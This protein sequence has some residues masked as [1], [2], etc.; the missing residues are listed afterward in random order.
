M[1]ILATIIAHPLRKIAGATNAGR[2]LSVAT[3]ELADVELAIMWDRDETLTIGKLPVRH[4]RCTN[5]L[6]FVAPWAPRSVRV[7][8]YDSKIPERIRVGD[9]DLVHIH[10]LVPTFA[11]ERVARACRRRGIPYVISTHGFNELSRYAAING[12]GRL[13]S[14]LVD[15]AITRPFRR[16]VAGAAGIFALSDREDDMLASL[17]VGEERIHVVT[18]GVNEFYLESPAAEELAAARASFRIGAGPI[19]LFMGSLHR[20]KGVDVFL[21][22]LRAARGPF[23]AVVA[24]KFK[25]DDERSSLLSAARLDDELASRVVFTG[26]VSDEELR[27]LYHIADLFV[28]PTLA[29]SLPLV[30]LEAMACGLPVVSTTVGGIPFAVRPEAGILVPPG[31]VAAVSLAV[32]ELL[33]D[34]SRRQAMG[35]AARA[36]VVETFRWSAAAGRALDG[37]HTVLEASRGPTRMPRASTRRNEEPV[38]TR[39]NKCSSFMNN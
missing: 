30:V 2:D 10:N 20:Y 8:L 11:A 15:F 9:H 1:K 24:G 36:R 27:A 5:P 19:L 38:S 22:S 25:D 39:K 34:P 33:A 32:N 6:D 14:A 26:G 28:Y 12:F 21:K 18:N 17:G 13:K 3:A 29:D 23:Q 31:D 7:P 35:T 37:Y 4:L 16:I